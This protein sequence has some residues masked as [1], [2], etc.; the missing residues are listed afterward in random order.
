MTAE[1]VGACAAA[2]EGQ[3]DVIACVD[4]GYARPQFLDDARTLVAED[5]G[6]IVSKMPFPREQVGMTHTDPGNPHQHLP[7]PEGGQLDLLNGKRL[8]PPSEYGG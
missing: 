1:A 4:A 3:D 7:M 2:V 5:D 8:V 6:K